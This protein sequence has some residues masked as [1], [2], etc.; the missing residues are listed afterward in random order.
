[1]SPDQYDNLLM[2]GFVDDSQSVFSFAILQRCMVDSWDLWDDVRPHAVRPYGNRQVW[3]GYDPS[4]TGDSAG[5]VVVA[6]P[7]VRGGKF[8]VLERHQFRNIDFE[9]QA[10][11]IEK[12]TQRY[13]VAYMGID[14]TGIGQGVYQLVK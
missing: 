13:T 3:V 2:C 1:Y 9:A 12:I 8:R 10:A 14:T 11:A 7:V 4:H 5:L 6:P